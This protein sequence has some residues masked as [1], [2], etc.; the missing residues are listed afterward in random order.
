LDPGKAEYQGGLGNGFMYT[1]KWGM[2]V[3]AY[4]RA[5]QL[6]GKFQRQLQM[7]QQYEAQ[8]K[9]VQQYEKKLE[10]KKEEEE[11]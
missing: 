6:G 5:C 11:E 1:K 10:Q 3:A 2:A 4:T 7:A 8:Q 9:Q